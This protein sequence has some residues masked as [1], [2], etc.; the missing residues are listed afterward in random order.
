MAD[1]QLDP[2]TRRRIRYRLLQIFMLGMIGISFVTAALATSTYNSSI[3][4][5][6]ALGALLISVF[7]FWW[8][9]RQAERRG[10]QGYNH[11]QSLD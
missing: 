11:N 10:G 9:G 6:E 1:Y 8:A 7:G 5:W 4:G 2:M 3:L